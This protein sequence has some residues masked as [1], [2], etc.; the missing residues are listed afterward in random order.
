MVA[1]VGRG[2]LPGLNENVLLAEQLQA[3]FELLRNHASA[4]Q[5]LD[6]FRDHLELAFV[7]A[8]R[9]DERFVRGAVLGVALEKPQGVSGMARSHEKAFR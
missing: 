3:R 9:S 1:D 8:R 4:P 6:Q 5:H 2:L 7:P